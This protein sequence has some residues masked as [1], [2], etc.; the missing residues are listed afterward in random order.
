MTNTRTGALRAIVDTMLRTTPD[1]SPLTFRL[2]RAEEIATILRLDEDAT[3]LYHL[4]GL[5]VSLPRSHPY[6]R[7]E[8]ER[9]AAQAAA[10]R[11]EFALLSEEIAGFVACDFVDGAPFLDQLSVW[12]DFGGRGIGSLLLSRA[13]DWAAPHGRLWLTTYD[14]VPWN[15]P[16]YERRGFEIVPA[17]ACG[18]ELQATLA[19]QRA[20][21]PAPERR[22][23]MR[24]AGHTA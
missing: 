23:A 9:W 13:L 8:E 7:H 24:W 16:F 22:I 5:D 17:S 1:P 19:E 14:G 4:V 6:A 10:D 18:P 12:R 15:R 11:V 20:A 3:E 2:A 21:L